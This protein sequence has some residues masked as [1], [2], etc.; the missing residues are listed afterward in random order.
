MR[1]SLLRTAGLVFLHVLAATPASAQ[2]ADSVW[3]AGIVVDSAGVGIAEAQVFIEPDSRMVLTDSSG[4]FVVRAPV[5]PSLLIVRRLGYEPFVSEIELT[6]GRDRRVRVGMRAMPYQ[7]EA[8]E[9]R[10]R[11]SYMPPG[12]HPSLDDFYRRRAEGKGRSFTREEIERLGSVRAALATVPGV[13]P[14]ADGNNRLSGVA[15]T[16]C[17]GDVGGRPSVIAWFLDGNRVSNA[18]ELHD[19][20]IEAVEIYRGSSQLPAEAVGNA[21]AAVYVWT[22]RSP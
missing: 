18:P 8:M 11:R 16:R 4:A 14:T 9:T 10:S 2:E 22:R 7:L 12:A 21:C 17:S 6:P 13:R 1:S 5:G 15:L 20:D 3:V 19:N